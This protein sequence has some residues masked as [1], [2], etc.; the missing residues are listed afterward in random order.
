MN[1]LGGL[2]TSVVESIAIF[3]ERKHAKAD[4]EHFLH[5]RQGFVGGNGNLLLFFFAI[6]SLLLRAFLPD[7]EDEFRDCLQIDVSELAVEKGVLVDLVALR[8]ERGR[9]EADLASLVRPSEEAI[10]LR[11]KRYPGH[12]LVLEA[13][14][15]VRLTRVLWWQLDVF[16]CVEVDRE[17]FRVLQLRDLSLL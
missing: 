12:D 11:A 14:S 5:L 16:N 10:L 8:L 9:V 4:A 7:D 17:E 1:Q 6:C 15:S 3:V 2:D 13:L